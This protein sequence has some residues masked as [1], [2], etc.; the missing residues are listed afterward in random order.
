[1]KGRGKRKWS[2]GEKGKWTANPFIATGKSSGSA[3]SS[4]RPGGSDRQE[5]VVSPTDSSVSC[6]EDTD[7]SEDSEKERTRKTQKLMMQ[8]RMALNVCAELGKSWRNITEQMHL[9]EAE[10]DRVELQLQ[11]HALDCIMK[12]KGT[13]VPAKFARA[14]SAPP[15]PKSK[16]VHIV[17]DDEVGEAEAWAKHWA[18]YYDSVIEAVP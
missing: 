5:E 6:S 14:G 13:K 4:I 9:A 17:V 10:V 1:M 16:Y 7:S 12:S 3:S 11:A 8:K 2:G 15:P 18:K